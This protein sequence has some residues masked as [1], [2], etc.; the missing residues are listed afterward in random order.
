MIQKR[1]KTQVPSPTL[2][3]GDDPYTSNERRLVV[4]ETESLF[5][6]LR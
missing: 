5:C 3:E 4:K 1:L 2:C 6:L